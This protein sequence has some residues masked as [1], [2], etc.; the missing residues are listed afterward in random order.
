MTIRIKQKSAL[1]VNTFYQHTLS[2]NSARP[3][4]E[5]RRGTSAAYFKPTEL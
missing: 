4:D 1:H 5:S 3:S 2:V